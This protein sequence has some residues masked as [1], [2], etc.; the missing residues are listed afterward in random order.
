MAHPRHGAGFQR[1]PSILGRSEMLPFLLF[2][3]SPL[4]FLILWISLILHYDL[5]HVSRSCG[6]H[7][8]CD[9]NVPMAEILQEQEQGHHCLGIFELLFVIFVSSIS[10]RVS[11]IPYVTQELLLPAVSHIL[12]FIRFCS[13]PW[14]NHG[15]FL[16]S[17]L[18]WCVWAVALLS[19]SDRNGMG[20]TPQV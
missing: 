4:I 19:C 1:C 5:A 6:F 9:S 12:A 16:L 20:E 18:S 3:T 8:S 15:P 11:Y 10:R 2:S 7:A 17:S 13:D 14:A